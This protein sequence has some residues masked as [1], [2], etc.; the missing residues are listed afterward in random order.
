M[1]VLCLID[2]SLSIVS[3]T[4][5]LAGLTCDVLSPFKT[6]LGK[7]LLLLFVVVVAEK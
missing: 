1:L 5:L 6:E 7:R 3:M 4:C 2:S